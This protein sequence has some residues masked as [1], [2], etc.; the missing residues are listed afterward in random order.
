MHNRR[1]RERTFGIDTVLPVDLERHLPDPGVTSRRHPAER[2]RAER[3][4][5]PAELCVIE[6]VE[7]FRAELHPAA[8]AERPQREVLV[9][10][11]VEIADARPPPGGVVAE[12]AVGSRI[13]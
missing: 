2:W 3:C 13:G 10:A 12:C 11:H 5:E 8:L 4:A 6:Y 7:P 1:R 9:D